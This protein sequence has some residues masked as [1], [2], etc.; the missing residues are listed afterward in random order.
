ME[1]PGYMLHWWNGSSL[2][3][4]LAT[5]GGYAGPF[6]FFDAEGRLID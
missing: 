5:I 4:H 1:P 3:S 6:P 2:V